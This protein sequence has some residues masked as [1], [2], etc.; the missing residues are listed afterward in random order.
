MCSTQN[1]RKVGDQSRSQESADRAEQ[2]G[3]LLD[4]TAY[5]RGIQ[6]TAGCI[7][8]CFGLVGRW[9]SEKSGQISDYCFDVVETLS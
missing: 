4:E 9:I 7:N 6:E 5:S 2:A 1:I 8:K 3:Q